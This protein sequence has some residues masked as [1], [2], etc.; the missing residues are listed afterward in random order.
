MGELTNKIKELQDQN[1]KL[2]YDHR[3]NKSEKDKLLHQNQSTDVKRL[4]SQLLEKNDQ[5]EELE[6]Q[7]FNTN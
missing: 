2:E 1:Y 7:I 4:E 6:F 3:I 5:I